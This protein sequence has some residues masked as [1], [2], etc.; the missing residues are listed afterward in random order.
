MDNSGLVLF[1]GTFDPI[2]HGHLLVAR[3]VAEQ[4]EVGKVILIPSA[5][6][7]H[8][9][10]HAISPAANRLQ[11]ASLAVEGDALFEISDCELHR[12]GPSYTLET[13]RHFRQM[14]GPEVPLYWLIGADSI[15]ELPGWYRIGELVE[16]CTIV[17]AGRPRYDLRDMGALAAAL[18]EG[19]IARLQEYQ[20]DTPLIEISATE[21]R[22]RV[23]E[24]L[25]IR[26]MTPRAV[27]AYILAQKL[28]SRE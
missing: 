25:S 15:R 14:Y 16:E 28:Y 17:S 6:P 7:P 3:A 26:Y 18:N 4:L 5:Q 8:K 24:G 22:R 23:A 1:G 13:V 27:E 21:M 12:S 20:M 10:N 19:Q 9:A 2:H 11:M